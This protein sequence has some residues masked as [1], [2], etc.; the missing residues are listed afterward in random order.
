[1]QVIL[2]NVGY[3]FSKKIFSNVDLTIASGD[4]MGIVGN[5]GEGKSTLLKCIT[6]RLDDYDG[7]I[8]RPKNFK[9]AVVAQSFPQRFAKA[10]FRSVLTNALSADERGYSDWKVEATLDSFK[11]LKNLW[12]KPLHTLSGGWQR[13]AMIARVGISQPDMMAMDEPTNHLDLAKVVALEDWLNTIMRDLPFIVVSHDRRFL[14]NC[15]TK[16][17]FLRNGTV[18]SF[19]Y[20]YNKAKL[21]LEKNDD[22]GQAQRQRELMQVKRL[23]RSAKSQRQIG[24]NRYSDA[25]LKKAKQIEKKAAGLKSQM[26]EVF[27]EKRRDIRLSSE[28]MASKNVLSIKDAQ[29][30][31]PLGNVLINVKDF[32]VRNNDRIV[33]LGA[34]GIGKSQFMKFIIRA[35]QDTQT[36]D[37]MGVKFAPTMKYGYMDQH[38]ADVPRSTT[39]Y[40]FALDHVP[41]GATNTRIVSLLANAGFEYETHATPIDKLSFGQ[42]ARLEFLMLRL[43]EPNIFLLD[44][45]TNHLDIDGQEKLESEIR[46]TSTAALI[47]SHDR[48][49]VTNV[50]NRFM[51]IRGRKI[52]EL[53][54]PDQFFRA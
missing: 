3:T 27:E 17:A 23:E 41:D 48:T 52:R 49:F 28:N 47:I 50:G 43:L 32:A 31:D 14:E 18:S 10:T 9:I 54:K 35:A 44:E 42:I 11:V 16:T 6:G 45:P 5:N 1:M 25:A 8:S 33:L 37:R 51:E 26:T 12:D 30:C 39:L 4:R 36:A 20:S 34:N 53:D 46:R 15:T 22:A 13:L 38:L 29:V 7:Q 2:S 40:N 19:Q 24:V 21:L